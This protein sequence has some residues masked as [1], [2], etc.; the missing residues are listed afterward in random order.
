M[1]KIQRSLGVILLV[2]MSLGYTNVFAAE[3]KIAV[4]D[5]TYE[6]K[7]SQYFRNISATSKTRVKSSSS[8]RESDFGSSSREKFD[9]KHESTFNLSE[10]YQTYIDR[11]ELRTYTA[12]LKGAMLKGDGIRLVQ[13]RPYVGKPMEKIYDII[14]RIKQGLYPGADYVLFGTVSSI[15]FRQEAMEL[16]GANTATLTLDLVTD[17][18]L[19][20]TKTYEIKAAF[21]ATGTGQDT[22]I[23]SRAGDRVVLNRGKVISETSKSLADAAYAELMTQLGMPYS[24]GVVSGANASGRPVVEQKATPVTVY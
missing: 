1:K 12:D 6:E 15:D 9:G 20:N 10:G 21:S 16:A 13:A 5:L 18:S 2:G 4:T 8:E 22:K 7:V 23:L 19:I 14:G 11:G 3:L 24:A 17:F